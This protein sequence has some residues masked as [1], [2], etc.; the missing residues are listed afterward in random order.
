MV[1]GSL[2]WPWNQFAAG[3]AQHRD[4]TPSRGAKEILLKAAEVARSAEKFYLSVELTEVERQPPVTVGSQFCLDNA[5]GDSLCCCGPRR[6]P[7]RSQL[8]PCA[9]VSANR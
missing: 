1:G 5:R 2:S 8:T 3:G 9:A 7:A 4:R 6:T